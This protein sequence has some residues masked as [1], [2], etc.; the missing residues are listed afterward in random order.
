MSFEKKQR[1]AP[2]SSFMSDTSIRLSPTELMS[3]RF[4]ITNADRFAV[5][6]Y[7]NDEKSTTFFV[8]IFGLH[9]TIKMAESMIREAYSQGYT[10]FDLYVVDTRSWLPFPPQKIESEK[11]G[12]E[13]LSKIMDKH[14]QGTKKEVT[15]L[16]KRVRESGPTT[17]FETYKDRVVEQAKKL[18]A[19]V[20]KGDK[21]YISQ[22]AKDFSAYQQMMQKKGDLEFKK[23]A[24]KFDMEALT[25]NPTA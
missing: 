3:K 17:P 8:R 13:L 12:S 19:S 24:K 15:D 2:M 25:K 18:I 20:E 14:I 21:D 10:Y 7:L 23:E 16:K 22:M 5:I 4:P 9:P 11:Q 1:M 6:A